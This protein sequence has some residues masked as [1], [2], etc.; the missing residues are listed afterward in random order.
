MIVSDTEILALFYGLAGE[1]RYCEPS[2]TSITE[3]TD[4][5]PKK[6]ITEFL[7]QHFPAAESAWQPEKPYPCIYTTPY[8]KSILPTLR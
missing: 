4:N 1:A 8:R 3:F 2:H 7:E 6:E 5:F